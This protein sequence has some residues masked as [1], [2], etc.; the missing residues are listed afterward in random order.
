MPSPYS[1]W[2]PELRVHIRGAQDDFLEFEVLA[3]VR[4]Y[5]NRSGSAAWR[6]P[7]FPTVADQAEY[8]LMPPDGSVVLYISSVWK[9]NKP[10]APATMFDEDQRARVLNVSADY[11]DHPTT[12]TFKLVGTPIP[13]G[14]VIYVETRLGVAPGAQ[15]EWFSDHLMNKHYDDILTGAL[16]RLH[17]LPDK[18]WTNEKLAKYYLGEYK[19]MAA[20]AREDTMKRSVYRETPFAFP[21]GWP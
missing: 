18:P 15:T 19:S 7:S 10:L 1:T 4:D 14:D 16:A 2:V 9:N 13:E 20:A 3:T 5:Y 8:T 6:V 11:F 21:G 17:A 12:N